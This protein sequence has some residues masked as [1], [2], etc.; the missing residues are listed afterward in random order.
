MRR[1][2]AAGLI[3][4]L[5]VS[6][7]LFLGNAQVSSNVISFKSANWRFDVLSDGKS[8]AVDSPK[9]VGAKELRLVLQNSNDTKPGIVAFPH[10]CSRLNLLLS[11]TVGYRV[12]RQKNTI[13]WI[14][15]THNKKVKW[16]FTAQ[17]DAVQSYACFDANGMK[18]HAYLSKQNV[19]AT[20]FWMLLDMKIDPKF[21]YLTFTLTCHG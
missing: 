18:S 13:L 12:R 15:H 19:D 14:V 7:F 10:C 21:R 3:A 20:G 6:T 4:V 5:L 9:H 11:T 8:Y 16:L 1:S 2:L 17:L